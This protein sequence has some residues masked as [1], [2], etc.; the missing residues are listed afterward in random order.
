[1]L[2]FGVYEFL[3]DCFKGITNGTLKNVIRKYYQFSIPISFYGEDLIKELVF[4][5]DFSLLPKTDFLNHT[6][7]LRYYPRDLKKIK[8]ILNGTE[9]EFK[10]PYKEEVNFIKNP[11]IKISVVSEVGRYE[12]SSEIIKLTKPN[13]IEFKKSKPRTF[14]GEILRLAK[15]QKIKDNEY[16]CELERATYFDQVRTNLTIDLPLEDNPNKNLRILDI[17]KKSGKLKS[18]EDSNLVNSIGVSTV[19]T[20]YSKKRRDWFYFMK[21]RKHQ[22]GVFANM[23]STISGVVEPPKRNIKDLLDHASNELLREFRYE[24]GIS[25]EEMSIHKDKYKLIPLAFTREL[26][27]GGK[28]QF[29]FLLIIPEMNRK[30]FERK[31]NKSVEGTYEFKSDWI[32]NISVYKKALSPEF[33]TNLIYAHEYL[34][35]ERFLED[36]D[37]INLDLK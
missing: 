32:S 27:R 26:V 23:L 21:I 6:N 3:K 31:F 4:E 20:F 5:R 25:K 1:M 30:E 2:E 36:A 29:F 12:M 19:V 11:D 15:F 37:T 34:Q 18:F 17:E 9:K 13:L 24:T 10:L 22:Q 14:D 7:Y 28:P 16:E 35:K 33:A 8:I